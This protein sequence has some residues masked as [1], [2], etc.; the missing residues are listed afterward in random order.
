MQTTEKSSSGLEEEACELLTEVLSILY[1]I[2]NKLPAEHGQLINEV[3]VNEVVL[4]ELQLLLSTKHSV[5]LRCSFECILTLFEWVSRNQN[6]QTELTFHHLAVMFA[7][8]FTVDTL[9]S[10]LASSNVDF[11]KLA[12]DTLT[13]MIKSELGFSMDILRLFRELGGCDKVISLLT[14]SKSEP[15][16]G[17][18]LMLLQ[19][20]TSGDD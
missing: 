17:R 9:I 20:M 16:R 14:T 11:T 13:F 8:S 10:I 12:A 15:V 7:N 6:L 2:V 4:N 18:L 5:L 3:L 19:T 1:K